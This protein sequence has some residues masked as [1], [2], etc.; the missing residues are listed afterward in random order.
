MTYLWEAEPVKRT[1]NIRDKQILYDNAG[2]KCHACGK[3]IKFSEMQVGHKK[4]FSKGGT[5]T[6]RN[7]VCLCY[8]CN[9]LQGTDSWATFK[10][11]MQTLGKQDEISSMKTGLQGLTI[12]QLKFLSQKHNVRVKGTLEQGLLE[13]YRRPPTKT[14]Y[15]KA[16]AKVVSK[17][18]IKRAL[19]E[20]KN[21]PKK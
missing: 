7:L 11:K 4:P 1:L 14:Q 10:K 8:G 13:D 15:V 21:K 12:Q 2:G 19:Q 17:N 18:D 5:T 9:K 20:V 3:K 6:L 16:L